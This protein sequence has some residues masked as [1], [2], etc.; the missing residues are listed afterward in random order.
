MSKQIWLAPI[1]SDNRERLIA[2]ASDVLASGPAEALLYIAASRPLLELAADRLLDGGR[3]RGVWGSLPVHLFR[4]FAR[5][6]LATAIE[7]ETGLHY[8]QVMQEAPDRLRIRAGHRHPDCAQVREAA[9][10]GLRNYLAGLSLTNITVDADTQ[11]PALDR[12]G[13]LRQVVTSQG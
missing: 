6:V 13:K 1:L 5:F 12:S 3:N 4:G 11:E 2:R 9:C 10:R 8:F 7:E